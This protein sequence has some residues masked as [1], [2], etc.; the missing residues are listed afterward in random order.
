M[1]VAN[2]SQV[3]HDQWSLTTALKLDTT[4][5]EVPMKALAKATDI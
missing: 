4:E 1:D 5:L 3:E 2:L